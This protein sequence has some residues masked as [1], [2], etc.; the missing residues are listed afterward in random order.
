M[1][2][3]LSEE[4]AK[5]GLE[6]IWK[7]MEHIHNVTGSW[8]NVAIGSDFDGFTDPTDDLKDASEYFRLTEML[9]KK[10]LDDDDIMRILGRN[11]QRV[12]ELGWV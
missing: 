3:W 1:T 6:L 9:R 5:N 7:T 12:L 8:G 4:H 11:A 2:Y 10:G